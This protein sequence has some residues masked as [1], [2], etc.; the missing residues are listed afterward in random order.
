MGGPPQEEPEAFQIG[1]PTGTLPQTEEGSEEKDVRNQ[2]AST[3]IIE[4]RQPSPGR[5]RA[6]KQKP[7]QDREPSK[8]SIKPSECREDKVRDKPGSGP[9][10]LIK[11]MG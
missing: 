3:T 10:E 5:E 2:E 1:I 6:R 4:S 7:L 9:M 8:L 11:K